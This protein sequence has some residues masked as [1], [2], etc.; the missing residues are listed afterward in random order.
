MICPQCGTENTGTDRFCLRCGYDLPNLP[1]IGPDPQSFNH[2]HSS[3]PYQQQNNPPQYPQQYPQQYP[4]YPQYPHNQPGNG[5]ATAALVCGIIGLVFALAMSTQITNYY[6]YSL[7]YILGRLSVPLVLSVV[8][9]VQACRAKKLGYLRGKS[10]AGLVLG[11]IA[12]SWTA[13]FLLVGIA[14][15][16]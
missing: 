3:N 4:P 8:A 12:V 16:F 7:A 5:T 2:Q 10:T 13:I 11:I 14:D 9:I 6:G 15:N 1:N